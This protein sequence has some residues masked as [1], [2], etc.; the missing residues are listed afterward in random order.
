MYLC[1]WSY[2][3]FPADR[4]TVVNT[5]VTGVEHDGWMEYDWAYW[6]IHLHLSPADAGI[7]VHMFGRLH[8]L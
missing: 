3:D 7:K 4:V 2:S 8:V 6:A 5:P 1:R